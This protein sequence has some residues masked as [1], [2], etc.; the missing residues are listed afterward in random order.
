LNFENSIFTIEEE[1]ERSLL[2][3]IIKKIH[4][5]IHRNKHENS[6]KHEN[7]IKT[8]YDCTPSFSFDGYQFE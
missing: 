4:R 5:E 8:K 2:F 7:S 1:K 6:K 3:Q